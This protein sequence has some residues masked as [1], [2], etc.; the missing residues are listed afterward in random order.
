MEEV[1]ESYYTGYINNGQFF[2][3][4]VQNWKKPTSQGQTLN[5]KGWQI[6]Q[7]QNGKDSVIF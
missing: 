3:K 5:L 7:A 2:K 4:K 6:N 1:F